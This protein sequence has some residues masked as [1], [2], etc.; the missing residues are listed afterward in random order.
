MASTLGRV[1]AV[2]STDATERL[3]F[4]S[5]SAGG[6]YLKQ[7]LNGT[8]DYNR[9]VSRY[10][11]TNKPYKGYIWT[12]PQ[13]QVHQ[14]LTS[15]PMITNGQQNELAF[16][17][18]NANGKKIRITPET[19]RRISIYD[20][21]AVVS[22]CKCPARVYADMC[23]NHPEVV[24]QAQN[25]KFE[26][27]GQRPTPVTDI[28]GA[29]MIMN[30]L[31]GRAAAVF[32]QTTADV[33]IRY[34]GGDE[35]LIA[36]VKRNAEVQQALPEDNPMRLCGEAVAERNNCVVEV[37]VPRQG[38]DVFKFTSPTMEGQYLDDFIDENVVYLLSFAD[39]YI[40]F[41]KSENNW[42]RMKKHIKTYP[43]AQLYCMYRVKYMKRIENKFKS[44]MISRGLLRNVTINNNMYNEI[45]TG[46]SLPEAEALLVETITDCDE[47]DITRIRLEELAIEK[48]RIETELET[49]KQQTKLSALKLLLEKTDDV[50]SIKEILGFMFK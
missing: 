39:S 27:A 5:C 38:Y 26:G 41:G 15:T 24:R 45:A 50:A 35:T 40:K 34:V 43:D 17:V 29:V 10:V 33:F 1:Y 30:L 32:R 16:I 9:G 2:S 47:D 3:T 22:S 37:N 25:F 42:E 44:K 48:L 7:Q 4:P 23:T 49:E 12:R 11:N 21:I 8:E 6:A 36:E 20:L 31:P 13:T 46:I 14:A 19:P 28:K 18:N